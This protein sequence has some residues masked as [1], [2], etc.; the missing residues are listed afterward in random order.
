[1]DESWEKWFSDLEMDDDEMRLFNEHDVNSL[2]EELMKGES[3]VPY[4]SDFAI[5][6]NNNM[7]NLSCLETNTN[8]GSEKNHEFSSFTLSFENSTVVSNDADEAFHAKQKKRSTFQTQLHIMSERKR[9]RR[10]KISTMREMGDD[11]E[12]HL[13]VEHE[14]NSLEEELMKEESGSGFGINKNNN[15]MGDGSC[16]KKST[17]RA[18][19]GS[20]KQVFSSCTLAFEDSTVVSNVA[21]AAFHAKPEKKKSTFQTEQHIMAERKRREKISTMMIELSTM[22]PGLKKLD[23]I[24]IVGKTIDYVKHLQNRVNDLQEQKRKTESVKCCKNKGSN[25]NI[26]EKFPKVDA[27]VS[28]KDVRI[29]VICDRRE[30]IVTKLFSKLESH[31]LSIVCSSVL[32]LG[33]SALNISIICQVEH[34]S[35]AIHELVNILNEDLLKLYNLQ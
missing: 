31:H 17:Q 10:E 34:V 8:S 13:F 4:D 5:N 23:K 18:N 7:E 2:E 25:V 20:E 33:S 27:S 29:R 26:S 3:S 22:L 21:D 30:H 9:K 14:M 12:F 32:P 16:L 15:N 28:G 11:D 35:M 6:N 1:M 19:S 24:S